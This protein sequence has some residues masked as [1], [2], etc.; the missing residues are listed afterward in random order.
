MTIIKCDGI[1]SYDH[2]IGK[3]T[4]ILGGVES[5]ECDMSLF[6]LPL[7]SIVSGY[8]EDRGSDPR[9]NVGSP[10]TYS[11][12][13][14]A[15]IPL[16]K[17]RKFSP[18]VMDTFGCV[19]TGTIFLMVTMVC[20][21]AVLL[22]AAIRIS[23]NASSN[24]V[25]GRKRGSVTMSRSHRSILFKFYASAFGQIS[26]ESNDQSHRWIILLYILL[27]FWFLQYF[28]SFISTD[29]TVATPEK[30]IDSLSDLRKS[31]LQPIIIEGLNV[32]Q[33]LESSNLDSAS[34]VLDRIMK[35]KSTSV[36][37]MNQQNILGI[38]S[39]IFKHTAAFII[40][41]IF[42]VGTQLA[43]CVAYGPTAKEY[44]RSVQN[45]HNMVSFDVSAANLP[46]EEHV[47]IDTMNRRL[48]ESGLH[49]DQY[50]KKSTLSTE[51]F[52]LA[53]P[54]Q[55]LCLFTIDLKDKL[56]TESADPFGLHYVKFAFYLL[57]GGMML[58]V[59]VAVIFDPLW[60]GRR[61]VNHRRKKRLKS[62]REFKNIEASL[63][64]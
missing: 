47:R 44:R 5:G 24:P 46:E 21:L 32:E 30:V 36:L 34:E 64:Q 51:W 57:F 41:D 17:E 20:I 39:K 59:V 40:D 58:A 25:R 10:T 37:E 42:W 13:F 16:S 49:Q 62:W 35:N 31:N 11:D 2:A 60:H 14:I 52:K 33:V 19:E 26:L 63:N 22:K 4:G 15:S 56:E 6:P 23:V 1:G 61:N 53:S 27:I 12:Y 28:T 43:A 29:L 7:D 45:I 55:Q 48:L 50:T 8:I 38:M 3:Y 18:T 54:E 9:L